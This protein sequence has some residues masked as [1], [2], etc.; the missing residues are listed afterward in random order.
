MKFFLT[1][2]V[3]FLSEIILLR[4][5]RSFSVCFFNIAIFPIFFSNVKWIWTLLENL[6]IELY[7][8]IKMELDYFPGRL[9]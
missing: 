6:M 4:T 1:I 3:H 2:K 8:Y 9:K 7:L 5:E